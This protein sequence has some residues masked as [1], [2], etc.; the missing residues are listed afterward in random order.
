ML[1]EEDSKVTNILIIILSESQDILKRLTEAEVES[2]YRAFKEFDFNND[3]HIN[4]N[5]LSK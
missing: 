5:E 2:F 4:T 1:T 3:G